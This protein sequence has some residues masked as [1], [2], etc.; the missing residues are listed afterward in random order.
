MPWS[1]CCRWWGGGRG[2][3]WSALKAHKA[4]LR[5]V[6]G[7]GRPFTFTASRVLITSTEEMPC[8]FH[9]HFTP[10]KFLGRGW[11]IAPGFVLSTGR[12]RA[13]KLQAPGYFQGISIPQSLRAEL[14]LL[15][16]FQA[17]VSHLLPTP[18][19][20]SF[21]LFFITVSLG[22]YLPRSCGRTNWGCESLMPDS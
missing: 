17:L 7:K 16:H 5:S 12:L 21:P 19:H 4:T 2:C 20:G 13:I 11:V 22:L 3:L 9:I 8:G 10:S 14:S 1:R 15:I 18:S 6:Q